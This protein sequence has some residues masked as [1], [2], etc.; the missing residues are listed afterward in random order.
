MKPG[1]RILIVDDNDDFRAILATA[2]GSHGF[3]VSEAANGHEALA[4]MTEP[5]PHMAIVDLDMPKMNGLEFSRRVKEAAPDFPIVLMTGYEQSY[6]ADELLFLGID[7]ILQKPV[8]MEK[9]LDVI[10]NI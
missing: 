8:P 6:S 2:L 9:L 1:S 3:L 4:A 5:I 7:T 10:H